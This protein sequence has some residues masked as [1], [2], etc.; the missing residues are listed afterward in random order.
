MGE[1]I[2]Q[3]VDLYS[4]RNYNNNE[5]VWLSGDP[6]G[7]IRDSVTKLLECWGIKILHGIPKG[8]QR[9]HVTR[10]YLPTIGRRREDLPLVIAYFFQDSIRRRAEAE[11]PKETPVKRISLELLWF[12]LSYDWQDVEHLRRVVDKSTCSARDETLTLYHVLKSARHSFITL[13]GSQTNL[14][15]KGPDEESFRNALA[16]LSRNYGRETVRGPFVG[17][18][19]NWDNQERHRIKDDS[20]V[21][22]IPLSFI[23]QAMINLIHLYEIDSTNEI[24]QNERN[25]FEKC[26][27]LRRQGLPEKEV[28]VQLEFERFESYD[29]WTKRNHINIRF[30]QK[31]TVYDDWKT[32]E[33]SL[34]ID[35]ATEKAKLRVF[36]EDDS[37]VFGDKKYCLPEKHF[38]AV[39]FIA[40]QHKKS[41]PSV[42][43]KAVFN[44]CQLDPE[45]IK[46]LSVRK[47]FIESGGDPARFANDKLIKTVEHACCKIPVDPDLIEIV[48]FSGEES[49]SET[50]DDYENNI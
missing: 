35:D 50:G 11:P 16:Y 30:R 49:A 29:Q 20:L 12:M 23:C 6:I 17:W 22:R 27:E 18:Y 36:Q 13:H 39:L 46:G 7:L 34:G 14:V 8:R 32:A 9:V 26:F 1:L 2:D 37:V 41:N 45:S 28:A 42:T 33:K 44:Y 43:K 4:K 47:W 48:P 3:L 24:P 15:E 31:D 25:K 40:E 5:P 10:L 19:L 21:P 38:Q